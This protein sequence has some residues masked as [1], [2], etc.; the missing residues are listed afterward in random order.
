[1]R[2]QFQLGELGERGSDLK[3]KKEEE[4]EEE[5]KTDQSFQKVGNEKKREKKRKCC[6]IHP[7]A[8][9]RDIIRNSYIWILLPFQATRG[10]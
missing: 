10:R 7:P 8:Q 3:K 6:I 5:K 9:L 2:I 1:M 4:E